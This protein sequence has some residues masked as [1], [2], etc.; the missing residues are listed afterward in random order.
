MGNRDNL[1]TLEVM[2]E[3]DEAYFE[4]ATPDG[5]KLK[6]GKTRKKEPKVAE[7]TCKCRIHFLREY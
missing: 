4:K 1:Y 6:R 5:V 7:C 2:I 3:F